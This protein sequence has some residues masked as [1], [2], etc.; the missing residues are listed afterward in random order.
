MT[1]RPAY[2]WLALAAASIAMLVLLQ[3]ILLPFVAG[4]AIAYFLDPVADKL[5]ERGLGRT[6]ATLLVLTIFFVLVIAAG[7]M[8]APVLHSQAAG[9]AERLPGYVERARDSVLPALKELAETVGFDLELDGQDAFKGLAND[10]MAFLGRLAGK[11]LS[12]GIALFNLAALLLISPIVAFYLLRDWD[13]MTD[14]VD[15]WLPRAQAPALREIWRRIDEVLAGFIRGQGT[16][17]VILAIFYAAALSIAGLEFGLIIGLFSGLISFIPF[18]G[19][20]LGLILSMATALTQF[21]PDFV[22]IGLIAFIFFVGQV[23]E[24]NFLTPKLLGEKVGLHPVWVI[25]ALLAGGTLF[26]F[27]GVLLALPGAAVAG[28]LVR[29]FID[30]YLASP[31]YLGPPGTLSETDDNGDADAED[32]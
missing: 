5:E 27:V 21:W 8:L 3:S 19:A 7:L 16:V 12:S 15:S 14:R 11:A 30:R 23:L 29:F 20:T 32:A 25:F 6:L 28:V 13:H 18:V 2:T 17:C 1:W 24:G 22:Q 4:M 26:G 31:I 9:F 10:A